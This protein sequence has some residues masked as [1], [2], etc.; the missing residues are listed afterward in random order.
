MLRKLMKHELRATGRLMVPMLLVTLLTAVGA[1]LSIRWLMCWAGC[2]WL[3][4]C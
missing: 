2:C 4:P 1:N 3:P